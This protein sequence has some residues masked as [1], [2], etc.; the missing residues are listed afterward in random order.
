[1]ERERS[2]SNGTKPDVFFGLCCRLTQPTN[3]NTKT[4]SV[5]LNNN[6]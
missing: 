3:Q 5:Q 4:I 2:R 6:Y 1:M